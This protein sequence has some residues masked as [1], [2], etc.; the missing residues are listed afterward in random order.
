[1][2]L[3]QQLLPHEDLKPLY[4]KAVWVYVFQ[5]FQGDAMDLAAEDIA[6]RFGVTSWP[7]LLLADPRTLKTLR[8]AG[9][10]VAS[11][12]RAF[13]AAQERVASGAGSPVRVDLDGIDRLIRALRAKRDPDAAT[14][15]LVGPASGRSDDIVARMRAAQILAEAKPDVLVEHAGALLKTD[16]DAFRYLVCKALADAGDVTAAP[17]LEALVRDPEP[18]MN[19]NVV[20]IRAVQALKTC[21]RPESIAAV[22]P[23]ATTGAYFNGLTGVAVD[24]LAALAAKHPEHRDEIVARLRTGYPKVPKTDPDSEKGMRVHRAAKGLARRIH[25]AVGDPRPF[26][27]TYDEAARTLLTADPAKAEPAK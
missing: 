14:R 16:S 26:P 7:Q 12:E 8:S 13:A 10:S 4:D 22:G 3:E 11:F 5:T 20:R 9:R 15:V 2:K 19:P 6:I 21:G 17:H 18:S 1:M 27:A 23:Y 25:K 24:T